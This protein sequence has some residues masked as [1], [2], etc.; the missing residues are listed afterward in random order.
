MPASLTKGLGSLVSAT[1]CIICLGLCAHRPYS[2]ATESQHTRDPL[3]GHCTQAFQ[4]F[5][6]SSRPRPN[7]KTRK[8][9][10]TEK[11]FARCP[12]RSQISVDLATSSPGGRG[13][14]QDGRWTGHGASRSFRLSHASLPSVTYTAWRKKTASGSF[15]R[16]PPPSPSLLFLSSSNTDVAGNSATFIFA[17]LITLFFCLASFPLCVWTTSRAVPVL[18]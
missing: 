15:S 1:D 7:W 5:K 16:L 3:R 9:K 12:V 2:R 8:K 17:L 10:N 4:V 14:N 11:S 18:L 13:I 6:Q